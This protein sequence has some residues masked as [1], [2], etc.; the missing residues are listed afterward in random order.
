MMQYPVSALVVRKIGETL[1]ESVFEELKEAASILRVE[2]KWE[3][4]TGKSSKLYMRYKPRGNEIIFRGAD[5][6]EKMKSIKISKFPIAIL[7]IEELADFHLEQDVRTIEN[8]VLRA[9]LPK[10]L[11]YILFYTYNPPKKKQ[12]W[13]NQKYETQL[14]SKNT[15]VHH[16]T[17]LDNEHISEAFIEEAEETKARNEATYRWE[18][19]GEPIGSGVVPFNNLVF[20]TIP[21]EEYNTF[22]NI[23][24]GIDW[25]YAVDP[26]AMPRWHYDKKRRTIY[27][28]DEVGGV[29][30]SNRE[31]ARQAREKGYMNY[32]TTSDVS[33]RDINEMK[34]E[35]GWP[36]NKLK[37]AIK[38]A[39]SV[40]YGENWLDD[41]E[42]IVIDPKRTP[43]IAREFEAADYE[44]DKDGN[45]MARLK[46][47]NNHYIDATRYAFENDMVRRKR[48]N[49]GHVRV[50]TGWY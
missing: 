9:K 39:G 20:R 43:N 28:M 2:D 46:D 36:N 42:A 44:T 49:S 27:A 47:V 18:Y 21:D 15:H 35:H 30:M 14:V 5:K 26:V 41:L 25:G 3:Y 31:L 1:R 24:Q 11:F 32:L 7:W 4:P 34:K 13:V 12:S 16:S 10:G 45:P 48:E 6:A 23:R 19:L 38:G 17:Y 33:P 37:Q 40:E 29:K 22:D 8:S 50:T